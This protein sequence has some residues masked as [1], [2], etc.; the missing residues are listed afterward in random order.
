ML[1][2]STSPHGY[3]QACKAGFCDLVDLSQQSFITWATDA[4]N[5]ADDLRL[6]ITS[7]MNMFSMNCIEVIHNQFTDMWLANL[8][9][10]NYI[11]SWEHKKRLK[12]LYYGTIFAFGKETPIS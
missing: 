8:K 12:Q 9:N 6:D 11:P 10:R 3:Q 7:E 4:L 1:P 5:L 2:S